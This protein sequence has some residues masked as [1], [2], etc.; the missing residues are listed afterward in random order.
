MPWKA[1]AGAGGCN[2]KMSA[3]ARAS[4]QKRSNEPIYTKPIWKKHEVKRRRVAFEQISHSATLWFRWSNEHNIYIRISFDAAVHVAAVRV[5]AVPDHR[6]QMKKKDAV[7]TPH[8]KKNRHTN[9][10]R[11]NSVE[12]ARLRN[13]KRIR[14][15]PPR[16]MTRLYTVDWSSRLRSVRSI[17]G[18]QPSR[19]MAK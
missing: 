14:W 4:K 13:V 5:A 8:K 7:K 10:T 19:P 11:V 18:T 1:R 2:D 12:S 15:K 3:T 6:R 17:L 9:T 16:F